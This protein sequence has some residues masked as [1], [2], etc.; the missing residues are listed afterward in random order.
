MKNSRMLA[1][2]FPEELWHP[3]YSLPSLQ[4]RNWSELDVQP[5]RSLQQRLK[6]RFGM[7]KQDGMPAA[8]IEASK[9]L[10]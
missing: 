10:Q 8:P 9:D 6:P 4:A 7:M 2:Q 5:P 3:H 1:A